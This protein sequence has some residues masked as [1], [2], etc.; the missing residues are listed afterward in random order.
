M[1]AP[2]VPVEE[3]QVDARDAEV[4]VVGSADV[5]SESAASPD[6]GSGVV[7]GKGKGQVPRPPPP[8]P[9]SKSKGKG[10]NVSA[11]IEKLFG[12]TAEQKLAPSVAPQLPSPS[13]LRQAQPRQMRQMMQRPAPPP[14]GG[15][16]IG[17]SRASA[18]SMDFSSF[19][20]DDELVVPT[21]GCAAAACAA[22]QPEPEVS[23]T[24]PLSIST[25]IEYSALPT[26]QTR[27]VFGIVTLK[28][29]VPVPKDPAVEKRQPL[30]I[31]CV[32]D[33]SGSMQGDKI[34]L[35]QEAVRFVIKESEP[36]DR[37][38]I[39]AFNH[40]PTRVLRLARMHNEG[41]NEATVA[42][43]R[44][45]ANGGTNIASGL[46][47][48]LEVAERR[49]QRNAVSAIL[50]LTDGQDGSGSRGGSSAYA[51]LVARAQ[52]AGCSLYAFGFGADHD[53][54]LLSEIAEQA[55]T[56][57]TFVEDVD[58]IGQAF[59]GA[60]GGLASVVA[61]RVQLTLDCN[62]HL[63]AAH[64]PFPIT[65]DSNNATIQIPD[66]LAG[67]R[68]DVLVEFSVPSETE[69]GQDMRLMTATAAYWD[70][71]TSATAHAEGVE[72][73]LLRTAADEPQPEME[74]DEEVI[75]QRDRVEVAQTLETAV[76]H[77]EAGQFEQAQALLASH[78]ERIRGKHKHAISDTLAVE[79]QDARSRLQ[80]RASWMDGGMAELNDAKQMHRMQRTTN[81]TVSSK[82][83][84]KSSKCMY[85]TSV[86]QSWMS[87]K[88]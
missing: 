18:R 17:L 2:M 54:R 43:L 47:A 84:M 32:L 64:T 60:M 26:G 41:K 86:Q 81:V 85:A 76:A 36:S 28:A 25:R 1:D 12:T 23:V 80:S 27:D 77:G 58:S 79:L 49:K 73:R 75:Q 8:A 56:P 46:E 11:A 34:R 44:L 40:E 51:A 71:E 87:K 62:V 31:I 70:L 68:R 66:M 15:P 4:A 53:A 24:G 63:K 59:A 21:P 74:P 45:A 72:M 88:G 67:E 78:E 22:A 16:P 14:F 69:N 35:V 10:S 61:Q 3:A 6:Q 65:R 37:L 7:K 42:T 20:D 19:N 33:V 83:R 9:P 50:L 5:G 48:A 52:R 13:Q 29:A 39:V 38:S 82:S 30:D 55:Q 57:F